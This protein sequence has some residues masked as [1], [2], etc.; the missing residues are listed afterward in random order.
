M[1]YLVGHTLGIVGVYT[2]PDSLPLA[3]AVAMVPEVP[4][5][6]YV[7]DARPFKEVVELRTR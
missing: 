7:E 4:Q 6:L 3:E 5:N 1:E 2:D